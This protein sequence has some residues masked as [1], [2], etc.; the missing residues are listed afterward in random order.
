[1]EFQKIAVIGAGLMGHGIAEVMALTGFEVNLNDVSSEF[2]SKG[3]ENIEKSLA[4]MQS[5]GKITPENVAATMSRIHFSPD[6][7]ASV[8]DVDLV[9]EAIP[10]VLDLKKH[11]ITEIEA[12]SKPDTVLAS[13]TSNFRITELQE[14]SSRPEKIV[15]MHFFNPP[16]VLKLVE[17]VKGEKTDDAVFESIF[18]LCKKIGKT[19]IKVLKDT[20]GFVVNRITAPSSLLN[21]LFLDKNVDSYDAIDR[22][23][24]NQGLPMGP[25][26][27]MDYVGIDTVVHSLEYY[28]KELSPEYGKCKAFVSLMDQNKLGR[29]TGQGFYLW[30]EGKAQIP[31]GPPSDKVELM[32]VLAVELNEAIKLIEDDVASPDDIET[33]VRLGM[34]RPFGPISVAQGLTNAEVKAKLVDLSEKFDCSIFAPTK[35]IEEGKM[36]EA[37][38]GQLKPAE[39]PKKEATEEATQP[40]QAPAPKPSEEEELVT[41]TKKGAV[42]TICLNHGRLNLINSDVLTALN[43]KLHE[44]NRDREVFVVIVTGKGEVFSAGAEL[45]QFF[46]GGID[47]MQSS[48][49]GHSVFK[50]LSELRKI[51]IAEIKGYALGGGMELSLACDI[52]VSTPDA[53]LGFPELQRGLVPGWGGTQ[54][55]AK[56]VGASRAAYLILTSDRITGADAEN[57]GLVSK[58]IEKEKID[59]E[60]FAFAESLSKKVAPGAAYLAKLLINKGSEM[61]LD[62]GLIMESISMGLLYG[63]EDIKEGVSAFLQKREPV[64]KGK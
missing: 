37:I 23:A 15:G 17:V 11:V 62:D 10:E 35:S 29:K 61:A 49:Q 51:T 19:P 55:M 64:F 52:R 33:G 27:L 3:K 21:C 56:L 26:E 46:A 32:D 48:R 5:G 53:K 40:T 43:K 24:K 57:I 28:S 34:N 14:A 20:P 38:S 16:V 18:D 50:L 22:F 58:L 4:R 39:E 44:V 42:A 60:T 8:S 1:M 54:R 13:N 25:Y 7:K 63:T 45:S 31:E 36:R 6:L 59:D 47:F 41:L 12:A 30:K 9:I 2:L